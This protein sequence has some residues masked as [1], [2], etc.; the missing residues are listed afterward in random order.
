LIACPGHFF[1]R[2]YRD[3]VDRIQ[4]GQPELSALLH[5]LK[6]TTD[7]LEQYLEEERDY[8]DQVIQEDIQD[9]SS[10]SAEYVELLKK[11]ATAKYVITIIYL[12]LILTPPQ[13]DCQ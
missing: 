7:D 4:H 13:I 2:N 9:A 8:L 1:F 6:I 10:I 5:S 12:Y 11:L 3:A